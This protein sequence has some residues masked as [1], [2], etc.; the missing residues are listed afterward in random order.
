ME[1]FAK[2][3]GAIASP[4]MADVAAFAYAT[5]WRVPSEVLPLTWSQVSC[6][7]A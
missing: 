7:R 6:E 1:D 4:I 3:R 5:D 2:V